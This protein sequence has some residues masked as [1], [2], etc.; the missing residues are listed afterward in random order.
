VTLPCPVRGGKFPHH[1]PGRHPA[2]DPL[3]LTG[4][5]ILSQPDPSQGSINL[6]FTM[7]N[8]EYDYDFVFVYNKVEALGGD[9]VF[10]ASGDLTDQLPIVV[11]CTTLYSAL[12]VALLCFALLSSHFQVKPTHSLHTTDKLGFHRISK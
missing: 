6:T 3:A 9:L 10:N 4:T 11:T 12:T 7:F 5:V 8:T 1:G 2:S